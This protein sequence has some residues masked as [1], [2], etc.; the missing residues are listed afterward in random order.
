MAMMMLMT[1]N[2][3]IMG[4]FV[5]TGPLRAIGWLATSVMASAALI[6]GVASFL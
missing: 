2:R 6:M 1:A 5:V 3:K 4:K